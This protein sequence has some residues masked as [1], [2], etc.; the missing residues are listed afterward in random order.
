MPA[1][2]LIEPQDVM[3]WVPVGLVGGLLGGLTVRGHTLKWSDAPIGVLGALLGG[4]AA[5]FMGIRG[6][7]RESIGAAALAFFG[8]LILTVVVRLVPGRLSS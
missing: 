5:E 8:A 1:G 2:F 7:S 3:L 4:V 6:E